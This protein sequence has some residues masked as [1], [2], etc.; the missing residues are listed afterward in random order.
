MSTQ[1]ADT[2][3]SC[4]ECGSAIPGAARVCPICKSFQQR[5]KLRLWFVS[6]NLALVAAAVS[7]LLWTTAQIPKWWTA[8]FPRTEVI[9][10]ACNSVDGAVL[11]NAG[12]VPIFISHVTLSS[13]GDE[14]SAQ[15]LPVDSILEPGKFLKAPSP[16][17]PFDGAQW[18]RH[19]SP[20]KLAKLIH[21]SSG[22]SGL[23]SDCTRIVMFAKNDPLFR[24]I[25]EASG[26]TL[27]TIK[28]VGYIEYF[29]VRSP[30]ESTRTPIAAVAAILA[31]SR[32]GCPAD[33]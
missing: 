16:A 22:A 20:E 1:A 10:T 23:S 32:T 28:A 8:Y 24:E 27:S 3:K 11:Y 26:P 14:W 13:V 21:L 18:V 31:S 17:K 29:P 2:Q 19:A 30:N 15:I 33:Q 6:S 7:V 25:S 9:A 5:W 12:D 4:L